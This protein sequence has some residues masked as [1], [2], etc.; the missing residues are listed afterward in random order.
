M[1][2]SLIFYLD[3]DFTVHVFYKKIVHAY[4]NQWNKFP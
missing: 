2:S 1:N 4:V 3:T